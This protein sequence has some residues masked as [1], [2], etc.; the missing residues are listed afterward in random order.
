MSSLSGLRSR[1]EKRRVPGI[2]PRK[3]TCGREAARSSCTSEITA[4]IMTPRSK[5]EVSTPRIATI[6]TTNSARSPR[7]SCFNVESFSKPATATSTTAASTGCGNAL[8]RWVKKRTTMRRMPAAIT[9]ESGVRAPPPSLTSDCD[10]PPLM[11]KPRPIPAAKFAVANARNSWLA[12]KR[13][14]CLAVNIRPRAAVSTAPRRKH[15][16]ANGSNSFRS[17]QRIPGSPSAGNPSGTWPS[18]FTP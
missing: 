11:G 12:S 13:P 9:D 4:P 1:S 18:N 2:R 5:P 17:S 16:R 15:A 7:Q 10:I 14:P 8:K 6:A 3:A